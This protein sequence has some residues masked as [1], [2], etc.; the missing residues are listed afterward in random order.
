MTLSRAGLLTLASGTSGLVN[1]LD[2]F[3]VIRES[4]ILICNVVAGLHAQ[5]I[6]GG[7]LKSDH[8]LAYVS[9]LPHDLVTGGI[10]H[11]GSRHRLEFFLS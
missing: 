7:P 6:P 11:A 1:C 5:E 8:D 9:F 4:L 10:P 3:R 2:Q